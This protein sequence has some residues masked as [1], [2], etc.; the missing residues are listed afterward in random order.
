MTGPKNRPLYG[1]WLREQRQARGWDVP[2][3]ARKLRDAATAVGDQI[4]EPK[5]VTVMIC[6]WES[7]RSG[8][9]ERYRL[10]YCRALGIN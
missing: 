2:E 3:M 10:L 5:C 6:R 7:N 1:Q 4:P 9:S 8:I